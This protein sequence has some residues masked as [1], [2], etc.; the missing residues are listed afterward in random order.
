MLSKDS[1][2][3]SDMSKVLQDFI[4]YAAINLTWFAINFVLVTM[5]PIL[6]WNLDSPELTI[7]GNT[8]T[9]MPIIYTLWGMH[10]LHFLFQLRI[11]ELSDDAKL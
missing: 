7:E 5:P 9:Y 6:I 2:Q 4:S 8:G 3:K 1:L 10:V 11:Y